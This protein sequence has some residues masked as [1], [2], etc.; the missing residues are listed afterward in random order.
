MKKVTISEEDFLEANRMHCRY[1][2]SAKKLLG[3]LL[4]VIVVLTAYFLLT[5]EYLSAAIFPV[6]GLGVL[7][8]IPLTRCWLLPAIARKNYRR[9]AL[10]KQTFTITWNDQHLYNKSDGMSDSV[11]WASFVRLDESEHLLLL[12][13]EEHLFRIVPKRYFDD[14]AELDDFL[15]HVQ[16]LKS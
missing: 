1:H 12:Y 15:L 7:L 14:Q 16:H 11:T 3:I 13:F 5:K 4:S 6:I 10:I 8:I 9:S 2:T